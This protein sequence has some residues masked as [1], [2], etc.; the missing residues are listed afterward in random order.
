LENAEQEQKLRYAAL[1]AM[2]C[3]GSHITS[4]G[5]THPIV[6]DNI[7]SLDKL[8]AEAGLSEVKILLGWKLL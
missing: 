4:N 2:E 1:L 8:K 3:V 7:V 5:A 6:R